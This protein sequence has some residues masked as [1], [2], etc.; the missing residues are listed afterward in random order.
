[1]QRVEADE[2]WSLFCP[3]EAKGL[4][5]WHSDQFTKLYISYE[6]QG[7]ARQVVPARKVWDAILDAQIETG[8]PY[9]LY[10]DACNY[11]SNQRNLGTIRSSNLC[12]EIIQYSSSTE[13]A[14]CNLASIALPKFVVGSSS[15]AFDYQRLYDVTRT[16]V[17]NLNIVIDINQYPVSESL[18]SNI[19]HRPIGLGVQGL[20][21]VFAILGLPFDSPRA[22]E[23]NKWIFETIYYAALT[24]SCTLAETD[25]KYMSYKDSPISHGVLQHD[26]WNVVPDSKRWDWDKLRVRIAKHGVRNSLLVAPMPTAST[27]QILGNN[28]CFEPFTS[29]LY[30]RTVGSGDFVVI[31]KHLVADLEAQNL[32]TPTVRDRILAQGG[33]VQGIS[34]ISPE[35]QAVYRTVWEIPQRAIIDMAAD[36]GAYIDQSQSMNLF[37]TNPTHAKLT[38]MHFHAWR[39]GL[40]TGMYYLRTRQAAAA[41]GAACTPD[42]DTCSA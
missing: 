24:E 4:A 5:D 15:T 12:T 7:I 20:A 19:K 17:R 35:L 42:C 13:T 26:M 9:M 14:V 36:R 33:S 10:K 31:N 21:D 32:W 37:M 11:K 38:G 22:R 2:S 29:N 30:S 40:K 8:T 25:G 3:M 34:T 1:M 18:T 41:A 23:I 28:E 27:S 16:V 39:S 6:K